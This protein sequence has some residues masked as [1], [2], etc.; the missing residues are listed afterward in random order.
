MAQFSGL[1]DAYLGTPP[2]ILSNEIIDSAQM[3]LGL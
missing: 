1:I 3:E 2:D